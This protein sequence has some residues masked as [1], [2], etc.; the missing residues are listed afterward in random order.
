MSYHLNERVSFFRESRAI[1]SLRESDFDTVSAYG[2]VL[3]NSIQADATSI[4]I[5]F[6]TDNR[7]SGDEVI[8]TLAF[9]DNGT[10]MSWYHLHP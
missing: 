3:D 5:R 4:N 1:E 7:P 9:G 2:E 6:I 8:Q 10:G